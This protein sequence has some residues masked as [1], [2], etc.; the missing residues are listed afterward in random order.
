MKKLTGLYLG[1]LFITLCCKNKE[2]N[3]VKNKVETKEIILKNNDKKYL[4]NPA[5]SDSLCLSET[6]R[7]KYDIEM[8]KGVY[9][10]VICFGCDLKPFENE[11]IEILKLRKFKLGIQDISCLTFEGQTQGCYIGYVDM[12]M[13]EKFGINYKKIIEKDA[14]QLFIE[15]LKTKNAIINAFHLEL[16]ERPKLLIKYN[17]LDSYD[18]ATVKTGI[19]LIAKYKNNY[20]FTDI[21]LIVEKDGTITSVKAGAVVNDIAEVKAYEKKLTLLALKTIKKDY[22]KWQPGSYKNTIARTKISIRTHFE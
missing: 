7:A 4:L 22:N 12:K 10:K 17:N 16:N 21:E 6:K 13:T 14:E 18:E 19:P 15:K 11:I 20:I 8:Y 2:D 9:V 1:I 5:K 3:S